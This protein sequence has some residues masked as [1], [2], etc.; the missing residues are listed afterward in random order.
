MTA[1]P[2]KAPAIGHLLAASAVSFGDLVGAMTSAEAG[3]ARYHWKNRPLIVFAPSGTDGRLGSQQGIVTRHRSGLRERDMVVIMV[4]G[5]HV[6]SQLGPEPGARAG[7]LRALYG[8]KASEFRA[9]LIG[10]D[11]GVK[12]SSR[13]PLSAD[14]LFQKIDDMPMRRGELSRRSGR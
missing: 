9:M 4:A 12:I 5:D 1:L 2:H 11:G 7:A 14:R 8:V 3:M 6:S 10:K 13:G